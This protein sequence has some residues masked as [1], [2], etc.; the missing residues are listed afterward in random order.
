MFKYNHLKL[1]VLLSVAICSKAFTA[2]LSAIETL[3]KSGEYKLVSKN[4]K[5]LGTKNFTPEHF[6]LYINALRR[7]DLDDAE[8]AAELAIKAYP[9]NA[10]MYLSHAGIM[11]D[12][13]QDS[14]FSALGYAKKALNSLKKAVE[15]KPDQIKYRNALMSFY[16]AAPSIAGGDI[17]LAMIEANA[18]KKIDSTAGIAASARVY[19][20]DDKPDKAIAILNEGIKE[21]PNSISLHANL[22]SFYNM[23]EDFSLAIT[24]YKKLGNLPISVDS[25]DFSNNEDYINAL[26][27]EQLLILGSYYQLGRIALASNTNLQDGIDSMNRYIELYPQADFPINNLPSLDWA[28]LR[29]AGLYFE[30]KQFSKADKLFNAVELNKENKQMKQVHK[31]LGKALKKQN[32]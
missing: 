29:L 30:N 23:T 17:E 7:M 26:H 1:V 16:I 24:T 8:D 31:A 11:G 9:E 10:D 15:L 4:L 22:A 13:A 20:A 12:Q 14:V 6:T 25:E 18:I 32:K 3:Y 19:S 21:Q 2:E 28:K 5:E 27:S